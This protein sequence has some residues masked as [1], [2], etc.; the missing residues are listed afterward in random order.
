MNDNA[1]FA[2]IKWARSQPRRHKKLKA[3]ETLLLLVLATYADAD[4]YAWPKTELLCADCGY[5]SKTLSQAVK[6]L[7]AHGLIDYYRRPNTSTKYRLLKGNTL[8]LENDCPGCTSR[9]VGRQSDPEWIGTRVTIHQGAV[10]EVPERNTG[11]FPEQ[12]TGSSAGVNTGSVP[13]RNTGSA[14][15]E[16][17]CELPVELPVRTSTAR[18]GTRAGGPSG[19]DQEAARVWLEQHRETWGPGIDDD[20]AL[21]VFHAAQQRGQTPGKEHVMYAQRF[22]ADALDYCFEEAA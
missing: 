14:P 1:G 8:P 3:R 10:S 13:K 2:Y 7:V 22:G 11:S 19:E 18:V 4:G 15:I 6:G 21:A 16:L 20:V 5:S 17:P 9:P 12:N